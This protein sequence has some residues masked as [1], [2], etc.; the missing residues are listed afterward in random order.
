MKGKLKV[1]VAAGLA[2]ALVGCGSMDAIVKSNVGN[3]HK[4]AKNGSGIVVGL[5][6]GNGKGAS[7]NLKMACGPIS[8]SDPRCMEPDSKYMVIAVTPAFGFA[9]ADAR[10][11]ALAESSNDL[12]PCKTGGGKGCTYAKVKAE[13]G[14]FGTILE[15]YKEGE[16]GCHWAGMPRMGGVVCNDWDYRKDMRDWDTTNGVMTVKDN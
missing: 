16:N 5:V 13:P 8:N 3:A 14:K 12:N 4:L 1:L 6:Y 15:V 10:V 9:A 7:E 11:I 2:F